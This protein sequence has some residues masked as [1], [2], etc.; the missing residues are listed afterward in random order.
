M[1]PPDEGDVGTPGPW[2]RVAAEADDRLNQP[3][4]EHSI[5]GALASSFYMTVFTSGSGLTKEECIE[6]TKAYIQGMIKR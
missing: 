6:L 5:M 2:D 4:F 3:V 1:P